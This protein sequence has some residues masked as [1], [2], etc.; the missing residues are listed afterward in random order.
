M[1]IREM[2]GKLFGRSE[3]PTVVRKESR[4]KTRWSDGTRTVVLTS[5][6]AINSAVIVDVN[7]RGM[8]FR[9]RA[10][11]AVGQ[12]VSV[13]MHFSGRREY[14]SMKIVWEALADD[15]FEFEYGARY[16]P[17]IPGTVHLLENYTQK[18]LASAA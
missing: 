4:A 2:L 17:T 14:L 3:Q 13:R 18:V 7:G 8:R 11:I 12:R 6:G 15:G 1:S 9:S 10:P 16:V 5:G